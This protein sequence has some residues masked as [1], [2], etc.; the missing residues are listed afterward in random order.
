MPGDS[1]PAWKIALSMRNLGFKLIDIAA[2]LYPHEFEIWKKTRDRRTYN[3]LVK[4]VWELLRYAQYR[5]KTENTLEQEASGANSWGAER[6]P[7]GYRETLRDSTLSKKKRAKDRA[8]R[9]LYEYE[10]LLYRIYIGTRIPDHDGIVWGTIKAIHHKVFFEYYT[11]NKENVWINSSK[12]RSSITASVLALAYAYSVISAALLV[13]G[14]AQY[15]GQVLFY[16]K[17]WFSVDE[18]A[19]RKRVDEI[20]PLVL[21]RVI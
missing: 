16:I 4:R 17:S 8:S 1:L 13:H 5:A 9:Q 3:K 12:R 14:K 20:A 19:L 15:R 11:R 6:D 7:L 2:Q 18:K 10:Q 21:S